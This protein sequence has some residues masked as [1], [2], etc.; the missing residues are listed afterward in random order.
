MGESKGKM[1]LQRIHSRWKV[2]KAGQIFCCEELT[3]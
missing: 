1:V 2:T 3:R